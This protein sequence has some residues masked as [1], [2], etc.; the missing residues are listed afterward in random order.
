M[1]ERTQFRLFEGLRRFTGMAGFALVLAGVLCG[2]ATF[3][4]LTGM[5]PIKPT[6]E[7]TMALVVLNGIVLLIMTLLV[8]GQLIFLMIEKRS[9][10]PG[11]S[12]HLRL[13]SLFSLIAVI[14]A[15]IVA[16]FA[17]VTLNRGLDAWFS[18]RTRR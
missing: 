14:P 5:T 3:A 16:I 1:T 2:L 4:I 8:L 10:T 12:L 17:T 7:S 18:L 13:V 6:S 11:A 9:G 15:I